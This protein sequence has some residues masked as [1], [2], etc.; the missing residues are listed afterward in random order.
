MQYP[1]PDQPFAVK[2]I[3]RVGDWAR[4]IGI[5]SSGLDADE[6]M[7]EAAKKSGLSDFG[8]EGFLPGLRMLVQSLNDEARLSTIGRIGAKTMLFNRLSHRLQII[9]YRKQRPE[10]AQQHIERPLFV[11]GLP[12]TGTTIF[13]ELL[14][15]DPNHRWPISY[16]VEQPLPPAREASFL[17][18]PRIPPIDKKMNEVETLAPGFQAIHAIGATLPQECIAMTASHF[19]SVMWGASFFIPSYDIWLSEQDVSGAYRW[20]RR[21]LQHLQVDY[22]TPRWLLKS[23]GHLPFIQA[24]VD[25]YPQAAIIQTHRDP[26]KVVASL[27]SVTCSL[28]SVFS[29]D[30]DPVRTAAHETAHYAQALQAGMEQRARIEAQEGPGRFFDVQFEDIL[31]KPIEVIEQLYGHFGL[32]WSSEIRDRMNTYLHNRPRE[33]HG[34]HTYTL[35]EFGLSAE[36]HGPLFADYCRRFGVRSEALLA[37]PSDV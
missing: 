17:T 29:D 23:P 5:G 31:N 22:S 7:S 36:Q 21:F 11:L 34:T 20:H 4:R 13:Y 27:S 12:R 6:L 19:M 1:S 30:V 2:A 18:D 25:E 10:V 26:M 33:K 8:D 15:Q 37:K 3:N 32:E 28:H 24:I 9:D 35:E 16:E 14:A